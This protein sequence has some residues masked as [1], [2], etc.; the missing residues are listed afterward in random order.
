MTAL[1]HTLW[2]KAGFLKVKPLVQQLPFVIKRVTIFVVDNS[3][4]SGFKL[5]S[6]IRPIGNIRVSDN[7]ETEGAYQLAFECRWDSS[8]YRLR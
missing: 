1:Q 6:M 4:K 7:S 5:L 8:N 2:E 3:L